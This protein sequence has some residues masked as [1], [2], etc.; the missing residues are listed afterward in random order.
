[1][2]PPK[3]RDDQTVLNFLSEM[4]MKTYNSQSSDLKSK[5]RELSQ[6]TLAVMMIFNADE[7]LL[8]AVSPFINVETETIYWEKILKLPLGSGHKGAL[9]WAYGIWTDEM[10]K[11]NC[12]DG[13]LSMSPFLKVGVLEALCLRWGLRG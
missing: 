5:P 8:N 2:K 3:I 12:F 1:M 11:G 9:R 7:F 10:P 13:A 6:Q 4:K